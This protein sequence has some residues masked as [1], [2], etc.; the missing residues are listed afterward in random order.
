M[1]WRIEIR[2]GAIGI[3]MLAGLMTAGALAAH[4]A[5]FPAKFDVWHRHWR[6]GA[7]G[8]LDVGPASI[9]FEEKGKKAVHSRTWKYE[10]IQQLTLSLGELKIITYEDQK[11]QLGRDREY[12]FERLP[13]GMAA[14]LYPF[15]RQAMDQRF[16]AN[17]A[18]DDVKPLWSIPAKLTHGRG[19]TQGTLTVGE[20]R[21]V[22]QTEKGASH[23]WRYSE[24]DNVSRSGPFDLSL[25]T[26]EREGWYHGSPT[27]FHF[28]LKRALAEDRY[29]DLWRRL[30]HSQGMQISEHVTTE[31]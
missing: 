26:L 19:G 8:V 23:T 24:I 12:V 14:Q 3:L 1:A 13:K 21:I 28:Q 27:E 7:A 20:D 30:N 15:F 4:A 2:A 11:W 10:D 16:S 25:L 17:L 29:N 5:T 18:D 22:Y 31:H 6:K 9:S